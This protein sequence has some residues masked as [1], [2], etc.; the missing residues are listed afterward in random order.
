MYQ[1]H[2]HSKICV[3]C[4]C[5][6]RVY[7]GVNDDARHK[8]AAAIKA[9]YQQE[10]DCD[11]KDDLAQ[12]IYKVHAAAV[13]QVDDMPDAEGH[14]GDDDGRSPAAPAVRAAMGRKK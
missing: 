14:A 10:A 11:G 13:E 7:R 2:F 12:V 6:E 5:A 9:C 4:K 3:I 8:A 1:A